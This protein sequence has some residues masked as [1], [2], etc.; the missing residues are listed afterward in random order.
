MWRV[1]A[2]LRQNL[3]NMRKSPRVADESMFGNG[4]VDDLNRRGPRWNAIS[5]IC[6]I[7]RVPLS[8]FA[9]LSPPHT[10]GTEAV[11]ASSELA[12]I[13]EMNHL[14]VNDS[15]RYAILM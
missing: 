4:N 8:L 12:R 1:A 2:A 10:N 14:M 3:R 11:W 9:C 15:M 6:C 7:I 5:V 13:S